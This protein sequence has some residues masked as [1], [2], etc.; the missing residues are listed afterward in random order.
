ME[1]TLA[2]ELGGA[3]N[4]VGLV[5][6][7]GKVVDSGVLDAP[8]ALDGLWEQIEAYLEQVPDRV[9]KVGGSL[10]AC[11]VSVG[12]AVEQL[13]GGSARDVLAEASLIIAESVDAPVFVDTAGRAFAL[14]EGWVGSARG[15]EHFA[16]LNI[17]D[18][19]TGGVVLDGR[20]LA[21]GLSHAGRV[22]Q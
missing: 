21:G 14:A 6:R 10:A 17:D 5:G 3:K 20:L 22:G 13:A 12:P 15:S 8:E 7:D 9:A 2:I 19:V 4:S 18:S 16:A 1:V 11:G